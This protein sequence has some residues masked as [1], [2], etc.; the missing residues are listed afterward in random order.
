MKVTL[1]ITLMFLLVFEHAACKD[2]LKAQCKTPT[3]PSPPTVSPNPSNN[4]D[5]YSPTTPP[6]DKGTDL[7]VVPSKGSKAPNIKVVGNKMVDE[8]GKEFRCHGVNLQ[9]KD[10]QTFAANALLQG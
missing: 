4:T 10:E 1:T 9:G 3:E 5:D 2:A 7:P 6:T 8:S